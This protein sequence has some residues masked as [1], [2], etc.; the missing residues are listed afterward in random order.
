MK[1]LLESIWDGR[2]LR[3][4]IEHS[5]RKFKIVT[6]LL[7]GG[8]SN[9]VYLITDNGLEYLFGKS[10]IDTKVLFQNSVSY[11]SYVSYVSDEVTREEFA[12]GMNREFK[13]AIKK[14][15]V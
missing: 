13:R 9:T 4:T 2:E 10:D 5:G 12:K 6:G 7:N 15:Y 3:E 11:S 1:T 8:G 14:V